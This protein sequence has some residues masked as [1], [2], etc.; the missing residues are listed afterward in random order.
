[1]EANQLAYIIIILQQLNLSIIFISIIQLGICVT[2]FD[3]TRLTHTHPIFRLQSAVTNITSCYWPRILTQLYHMVIK[4]QDIDGIL[5]VRVI[6]F[7]TCKIWCVWKPRFK[8]GHI[9]TQL[10]KNCGSDCKVLYNELKP[11]RSRWGLSKL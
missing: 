6:N 8:S 7:Q 1:M 9:C 11:V 10:S 5:V 2:G 3:K 4:Q